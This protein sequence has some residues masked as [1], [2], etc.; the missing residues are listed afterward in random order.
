V[1]GSLIQSPTQP[2]SSWKDVRKLSANFHYFWFDNTYLAIE[3]STE[4]LIADSDELFM[5][6]IHPAL[7]TI[8]PGRDLSIHFVLQFFYFLNDIEAMNN[9]PANLIKFSGTTPLRLRDMSTDGSYADN[10]VAMPGVDHELYIESSAAD[11][12]YSVIL[13]VEDPTTHAITDYIIIVDLVQ[14]RLAA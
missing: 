4:Y 5:R 12:Y 2:D 7:N 13:G 9:D 1:P 10:M 11:G 6:Y 14:K 8:Y 3:P